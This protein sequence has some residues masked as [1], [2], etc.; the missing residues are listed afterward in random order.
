VSVSSVFEIDRVPADITWQNFASR[1]FDCDRPVVVEGVTRGWTA[2]NT[3]STA[4]LDAVFQQSDAVWKRHLWYELDGKIIA[5]DYETP[6]IVQEALRSER[7]FVRDK[8]VRIWTSH[9]GNVTRL[10]YDLNSL[11]VFNVQVLGMKDWTIVNPLTPPSFHP[12]IALA[13]SK[14]STLAETAQHSR[15]RVHAGDMV[16]L[17][18]YWAH[19]VISVGTDNV[20]LNW[21]GT[22][23]S[24]PSDSPVARREA[25]ILSVLSYV[26]RVKPL[27]YVRR[28]GAGGEELRR[29]L[30]DGLSPLRLARRLARELVAIPQLLIDR[31]AKE[32][33]RNQMSEFND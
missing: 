25:E 28:Y 6:P 8:N 18:P 16:F 30:T 1:Y 20:N 19:E 32:L 15:F 3:W 21:V 27:G 13:R 5:D 33:L 2:A 12:G 10:H 29:T 23:R 24:R 9:K 11:F 22:K 17:P 4:H 14:V 26:D 7:S 31:E